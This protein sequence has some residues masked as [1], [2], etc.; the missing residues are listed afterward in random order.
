[1]KAK[2]EVEMGKFAELWV[3]GA[4]RALVPRGWLVQSHERWS[5]PYD[6]KLV[7]P[8]GREVLV[9]VKSF[10]SITTDPLRKARDAQKKADLVLVFDHLKRVIYIYNPHQR[11]LMPLSRRRL[12][13]WLGRCR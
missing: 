4:L 12:H 3:E 6:I 7:A 8:D 9:E 10:V 11:K 1:M 13:Y 2:S 5:D